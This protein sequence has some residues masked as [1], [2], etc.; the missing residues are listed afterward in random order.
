MTSYPPPV[1]LDVMEYWSIIFKELRKNGL[2][3]LILYAAKLSLKYGG[4]V[5]HL[6]TY[7]S[8]ESLLPVD[9]FLRITRGRTPGRRR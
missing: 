4:R 7:T 8:S 9:L 1:S 5:I 6:Q 3:S 2:D